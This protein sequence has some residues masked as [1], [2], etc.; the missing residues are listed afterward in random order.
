MLS[1]EIQAEFVRHF[2]GLHLAVWLPFQ[3]LRALPLF[4]LLISM[5]Y[6][7]GKLTDNQAISGPFCAEA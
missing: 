3:V 4:L 1:A 6:D 7:C 2:R 5:T